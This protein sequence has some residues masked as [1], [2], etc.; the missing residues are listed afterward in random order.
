[1]SFSEGS[2]IA[3]AREIWSL[4]VQKIKPLLSDITFS[5][6]F[7]V[8]HVVALNERELVLGVS[9]DFFADWF[10]KNYEHLLADA[11][12]STA[13]GYTFRF[14]VGYAPLPVQEAPQVI[15]AAKPEPVAVQPRQ[16]PFQRSLRGE[17][18]ARHSGP[19][20]SFENFV[21]GEEN[22]YAF[23]AA[24][25]VADAP[26]VFNPLYIYGDTG[27]GKTHLIHAIR[28]R[29]RQNTPGINVRYATCEDILNEFVDSI[30]SHQHDQFRLSTRGVDALLV[31]DIHSLAGK[32]RLQE[33]FFDI[34]NA[35]YREGKQI[36]LTSDK[37][38]SEI[39]GV[40]KRLISRFEQ[41]LTAEITPLGYEIRLA[42][43]RQTASEYMCEMPDAGLEFIAENIRSS[44]RRLKSALLRVVG[45]SS[46]NGEAITIPFIEVALHDML[47]SEC[48]AESVSIDQI[49]SAVAA[50][51]GLRVSDI[52]SH[53]RPRNIAE[54][55]MIAMYLAREITGASYPEIGQ[56]FDKT[57][58]TVLHAV[59]KVPELIR[60]NE[61]IRRSVAVLERQLK[62]K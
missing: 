30:K 4:A 7:E 49:Y 17:V 27:I 11:L 61:N 36:V 59:K 40:E 62:N 31:D 9:D 34:F 52:I 26:G 1:M 10:S 6:W 43:L 51:F 28:E 42:I 21:V 56:A 29:M 58:A 2:N 18:R 23:S 5:Q 53:H 57:H 45:I 14:D 16:I 8:I 3:K 33:Q 20:H 54:P 22:R 50:H 60:G 13:D 39:T 46:T 41:G 48:S 24:S 12:S 47:E 44:V 19:Q 25:A 32:E 35:L 38:P 37:P 15:V 55:R